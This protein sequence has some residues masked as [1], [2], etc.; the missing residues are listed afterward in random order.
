MKPSSSP[1]TRGIRRLARLNAN[2]HPVDPAAWLADAERDVVATTL[3]LVATRARIQQ[4]QAEP[5]ILSQSADRLTEERDRWGARDGAGDNGFLPTVP[6][7]IRSGLGIR[8]PGPEPIPHL[9][10]H[11][12]PCPDFAR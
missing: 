7:T 5:A 2:G 1:C 4:L 9:A 12:D 10:R 3:D 6:P 8:P 11:P